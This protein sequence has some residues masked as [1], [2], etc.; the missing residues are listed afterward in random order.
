[1]S[2]QKHIDFASSHKVDIRYQFPVIL[3]Q[4]LCTRPHVC[5]DAMDSNVQFF[6]LAINTLCSE[7]SSYAKGNPSSFIGNSNVSLILYKIPSVEEK[8]NVPLQLLQSLCV[9]LSMWNDQIVSSESKNAI[10]YI[11]DAVLQQGDREL[12]SV[13]FLVVRRSVLSLDYVCMLFVV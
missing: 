13:D 5:V 11:A 4:L 9:V 8:I 7:I 3:T 6:D 10:K 1:M 2:L 12:A